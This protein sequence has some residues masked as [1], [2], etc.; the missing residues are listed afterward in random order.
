MSQVGQCA[1]HEHV[2]R[3][4]ASEA[5]VRPSPTEFSCTIHN[6]R[7]GGTLVAM[8]PEYLGSLNEVSGTNNYSHIALSCSRISLAIRFYYLGPEDSRLDNCALELRESHLL[9]R[10]GRCRHGRADQACCRYR[11]VS[12]HRHQYQPVRQQMRSKDGHIVYSFVA[13]QVD[14]TCMLLTTT[15]GRPLESESIAMLSAPSSLK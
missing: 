9:C 3:I 10:A 14:E 13:R 8:P 6:Y 1:V 2:C 4:T 7:R 12:T 11:S 15:V 5:W